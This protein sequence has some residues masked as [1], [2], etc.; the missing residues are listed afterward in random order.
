MANPIRIRGFTPAI[1]G[2]GYLSLERFAV[3]VGNSRIITQ[4]DTL[5]LLAAGDGGVVRGFGSA[6]AV[7]RGQASD[8]NGGTTSMPLL[9]GVASHCFYTDA[10]G[11][12]RPSAR[13]PA[14]QAGTVY[15]WSDYNIRFV[16]ASR[17]NATASQLTDLAA[18][19]DVYDS[20]AAVSMTTAQGAYG[21]IS[22]QSID[23]AT[24]G[25]ASAN[26]R[27]L[28]QYPVID[29]T[30]GS[31]TTDNLHGQYVFVFNEHA[32]RTSTTGQ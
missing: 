24:L 31:S 17:D 21:G 25:T 14:S 1:V 19:C 23:L 20:T 12:D 18:L 16:G 30:F 32:Y 7:T 4:G 3:L 27:L 13:I 8:G 15:G 6:Q 10:G 5:A 11:I 29:N 9:V 26:F 22:Q 2:N 28:E